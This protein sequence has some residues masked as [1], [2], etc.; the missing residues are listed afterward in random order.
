MILCIVSTIHLLFTKPLS[1]FKVLKRCNTFTNQKTSTRCCH[2]TYI[3]IKVSK[4]VEGSKIRNISLAT[5][6][7]WW[8]AFSSK[9]SWPAT[10]KQQRGSVVYLYRLPLFSLFSCLPK[11][12]GRQLHVNLVSRN[13]FGVRKIVYLH[14]WW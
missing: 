1:F 11:S 2:M 3:R 4:W 10:K 13:I 7:G 9:K 5:N 14:M 6:P 8:G 12:G